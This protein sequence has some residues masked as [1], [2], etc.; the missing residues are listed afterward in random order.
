[1]LT[2]SDEDE[3]GS[4]VDNTSS[5]RQDGGGSTVPDRL[6]DTPEFTGGGS[7][8]TRAVQIRVSV[9]SL[10][11]QLS[12]HPCLHSR[13]RPSDPGGVGAAE[14]QLAIH[15]QCRVRGLKRHTNN[16][17]WDSFLTE[18]VVRDCGDG[19]SCVGRQGTNRQVD[20]SD[21]RE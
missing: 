13:D 2:G 5:G 14:R 9:D 3:G 15:D 10:E 19:G 21:S 1:M 7:R 8:R 11:L 18:K 16:V 17:R 12:D 4:S 6:V 20:G